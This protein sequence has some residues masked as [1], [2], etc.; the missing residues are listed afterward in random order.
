MEK[1][2]NNILKLETLEVTLFIE[3]EKS[4]VVKSNLIKK[5]PLLDSNFTIYRSVASHMVNPLNY[6][7]KQ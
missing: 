4:V 6:L 7:V 3:K 2:H 5:Y 1:I